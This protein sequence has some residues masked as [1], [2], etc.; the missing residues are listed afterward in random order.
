VRFI[1]GGRSDPRTSYASGSLVVEDTSLASIEVAFG[2]NSNGV[3]G[4][5]LRT[6]GLAY[7][8]GPN[9]GALRLI[10]ITEVGLDGASSP[11]RVTRFTY[12]TE[13][14]GLTAQTS[15]VT[16]LPVNSADVLYSARSKSEC[17][18]GWNGSQCISNTGGGPAAVTVAGD[19]RSN[20]QVADIDND[21]IPEYIQGSCGPDGV[22]D[23]TPSHQPCQRPDETAPQNQ[24]VAVWRV[25][26][27]FSGWQS[28]PELTVPAPFRRWD[29]FGGISD[30]FGARFID[31]NRN[32]RQD[33]LESYEYKEAG[34]VRNGSFVWFNGGNPS[35]GN[36]GSRTTYAF[37]SI[38]G[39]T[40]RLSYYGQDMGVRIADVNGDGYPDLL[41]AYS[42]TSSVEG[43]PSAV[44]DPNF[45]G[46]YY[47][48]THPQPPDGQSVY[49]MDPGTQRWRTSPDSTFLIPGDVYFVG[50]IPAAKYRWRCPDYVNPLTC[51]GRMDQAATIPADLG[52]QILDVNGDGLPDLVKATSYPY[53]S[54]ANKS[55]GLTDCG[56]TP[57]CNSSW[58]TTA[59]ANGVWLNTGRGWTRSGPW[60]SSLSGHSVYL[61]N[62]D[63]SCRTGCQVDYALMDFNDD[64]L[65]DIYK[66]GAAGYY[67]NNGNGWDST[68]TGTGALDFGQ[69]QM[70]QDFNGD[71]RPDY[72]SA[73]R[74]KLVNG[75]GTV[76]NSTSHFSASLSD[77]TH[78][79]LLSKVDNWMGGE[80]RITYDH[81]SRWRFY[82]N[83]HLPQTRYV[84]SHVEADASPPPFNAAV[85][86]GVP[87]DASTPGTTGVGTTDYEY[88]DGEFNF[89]HR[90]FRGFGFVRATSTDGSTSANVVTETNYFQDDQ[91]KGLVDD[92]LVSN[93]PGGGA[94]QQFKQY[95]YSVLA[96]ATG[97]YD[98]RLTREIEKEGPSGLL[99]KQVDYVYDDD[100][101]YGSGD[102]AYG[103][104][105]VK[106][107]SGPTIAGLKRRTKW[108]YL[109][110]R[111][112]WLVSL[113]ATQRQYAVTGNPEIET[114]GTETL[115]FY[116]GQTTQAAPSQGLLT[117]TSVKNAYN[118]V[119][120]TPIVTK[121]TYDGFGNTLTDV[122]ANGRTT[123]YAYDG[124][125]TYLTTI[126]NPL[127]YALTFNYHGVNAIADSR[128]SA[129]PHI[130]GKL[131]RF[132]EPT[133]VF[134]GP[135]QNDTLYVYDTIGRLTA[136]FRPMAG[137]D[138]SAP[139]SS[140]SYLEFGTPGHQRVVQGVRSGA[141]SDQYYST[142][143]LLDGFG[144]IVQTR[145]EL[146]DPTKA[147]YTTR[148]YDLMGRLWRTSV[149]QE[150][151]I[152][153]VGYLT[154]TNGVKWTSNTY[155]V[156]G[157]VKKQMNVDGSHSDYAYSG[158]SVTA[159]DALGKPKDLA[160]DSYGRLK[161]VTE[162]NGVASSLTQYSYNL[163]DGLSRITDAAGNVTTY[164]ADTLNRR[165]QMVD[166]DRGTWNY[167]Y[168]ATGNLIQQTGPAN[169]VLRFDYDELGRLLNKYAPG[170]L[171]AQYFYDSKKPSDP[172]LDI[173]QGV[174]FFDWGLNTTSTFTLPAWA[175][176]HQVSAFTASTAASSIKAPATLA[177]YS[178]Y[179][180][181]QV[182]DSVDE[183]MLLSVT[184]RDNPGAYIY[185]QL[186]DANSAIVVNDISGNLVGGTGGVVTR[187]VVV[188]LQTH[189]S[190][191]YIR[192]QRYYGDVEVF[193][194]SLS[195]ARTNGT[196]TYTNAPESIGR[197]FDV[198]GGIGRLSA[199]QDR[200]GQT[201]FAYDFRGRKTAER[202]VLQGQG[203]VT[204]TTYT[205]DD[206]VDTMRYPNNE[207]VSY[208]Y[209]A[210]RRMST[211]TSDR[212]LPSPTPLVPVRLAG[213]VGY[214]AF[215]HVAHIDFGGGGQTPPRQYYTDYT[216]Q[217]TDLR[218]DTI[219]SKTAGNIPFQSLGFD[220]D[221]EGNVTLVTDTA[222]GGGTTQGKAKA[223]GIT[224]DGLNRL[225]SATMENATTTAPFPLSFAYDPIGNMTTHQGLAQTFGS[226]CGAQPHQMCRVDVNSTQYQTLS[227]DPRGNLTSLKTFNL[228]N[229]TWVMSWGPQ[230][231]YDAESRQASVE[232]PT[233]SSSMPCA[234]P[235]L[236]GLTC[237]EVQVAYDGQGNRV[238]RDLWKNGIDYQTLYV[239]PHYERRS[240]IT[241]QDRRTSLYHAF[242]RLV[243]ERI[244]AYTPDQDS[245]DPEQIRYFFADHLGSTS[246]VWNSSGAA[247]LA[248]TYR[249]YGFD[250]YS[251]SAGS[252]NP[253]QLTTG[254]KFTGQE[255]DY[256][257][258]YDYKARSYLPGV[259]VFAQADPV[260]WTKERLKDPQQLNAYAYA[261]GNPVKYVDP[262]GREIRLG[263]NP[264]QAFIAARLM[265][266]VSVRSAIG[267]SLNRS[268]QPI[269]TVDNSV[270]SSSLNYNNLRM[271]VNSPGIVEIN[272]T[273][274]VG[275]VDKS[276]GKTESHDIST[277]NVG[278]TI[279]SAGPGGATKF[280]GAQAQV[281][282]TESGV[283][284]INIDQ[285]L[286]SSY[287]GTGPAAAPVLAAELAGH[288]VPG[289]LGEGAAPE[290]LADHQARETPARDEARVTSQD[291]TNL[292]E[293]VDNKGTTSA[294]WFKKNAPV[295]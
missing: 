204:D 84:V 7:G 190:V 171:L 91:L 93:A 30:D 290:S 285:S 70:F 168:D 191:R 83:A 196:Y 269:I 214:D 238:R 62:Q 249:P 107:E 197:S 241:G 211:L 230:F 188:D 14:M 234:G 67:R 89:Q 161:Q 26:G 288:A 114:L 11:S 60:S 183:K 174:A 106:T 218:L 267:L 29:E 195:R 160:Y 127:G 148:Q 37:P 270:K 186:R 42:A 22:D 58:P 257:F 75:G 225:T 166:P 39:K 130:P 206:L 221:F 251:W 112:P 8:Y 242:G 154:P 46:C 55:C 200:T 28:A 259:G 119:D 162:H 125:A 17:V 95:F 102:E 10:S 117:M 169:Y 293:P 289:L 79:D 178:G 85:R 73:W 4:T 202:K 277:I 239:G 111:T 53:D 92:V 244:R 3:G 61:H 16:G 38:G 128:D 240:S 163:L 97:A 177:N 227:Y 246:L 192:V 273:N 146:Q 134:G 208:A 71:G 215:G 165:R 23:G 152:G 129:A 98:R 233:T 232:I 172:N 187:Q 275:F 19:H 40:L 253:N 292:D 216:Y 2:T 173:T 6:Y 27:D 243:A 118:N 224:Y 66:R 205:Q 48:P 103:N 287:S 59:A 199:L 141:S 13:S 33:L 124:T 150:L 137:L 105:L 32:G 65:P 116:D 181:H 132:V 210:G 99:L 5:I 282:S 77:R 185:I 82:N 252:S 272:V 213:A 265:V 18:I 86:A 229:S 264:E 74:F 110:N 54:T 49:L 228:Q 180:S 100:S 295:P 255:Q 149:P 220:Y 237:D 194:T 217:P 245:N 157:R 223:S 271:A 250:H 155:D 52:T 247:E 144:R 231:A 120:G 283:T 268:G 281:K 136:S 164:S 145:S 57:N 201:S 170:Q 25:K 222:V 262:N 256:K 235:N 12:A 50:P 142:V 43:Y 64:G 278:V 236:I 226:S 21:G 20:V 209:D 179:L 258:L 88:M 274:Q 219:I 108:T 139:S 260:D 31:L 56:Q 276:T 156:L 69:G 266:P 135:G 126:T 167:E 175:S 153:G 72:F 198:Q 15:F 51:D 45:A 9:S 151:V 109:P 122:N 263:T 101:S 147:L 47:Q 189:P 104:P 87:T 140:Y 41:Y 113:P 212:S 78:P 34:N 63:P 44:H 176:V 279:P 76:T 131:Q 286:P 294:E 284:G 143:Y 184:F 133:D 121:S 182:S 280:G 24:N 123:T 96:T 138:P 291:L 193:S 203:Y 80:L 248:A 158:L 115:Y 90:E 36:W 35:G 68:L 254:Y 261:R 1:P 207:L 94:V 81:S 159:T